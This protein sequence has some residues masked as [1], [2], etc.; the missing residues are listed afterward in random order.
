ML[1]RLSLFAGLVLAPIAFLELRA[2]G[3]Q[4]PAAAVPPRT[5]TV[6]LSRA[7]SKRL[8]ADIRGKVSVAVPP[9]L[10]LTLWA[11][12]G[13]VTDPVAVDLDAHGTADVNSNSR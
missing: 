9:G 1:R 3:S 4:A 7:E 6:R 5:S 11:P 13:L 12:D 2:A 10:E 8:S